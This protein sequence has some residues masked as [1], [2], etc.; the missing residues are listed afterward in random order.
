MSRIV[1]GCCGEIFDEREGTSYPD[2]VFRCYDCTGYRVHDGDTC[3]N[4][5]GDFCEC[6]CRDDDG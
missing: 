6:E 1:C 4:C 3:P 2:G 5:G